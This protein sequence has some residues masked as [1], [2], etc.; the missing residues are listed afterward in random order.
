[1]AWYIQDK[2][3]LSGW[4]ELKIEFHQKDFWERLEDFLLFFV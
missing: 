2:S 3:R 4:R 1:M